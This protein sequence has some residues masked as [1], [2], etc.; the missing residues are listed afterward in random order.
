M[1]MKMKFSGENGNHRKAVF[2]L[3]KR[4]FLKMKKKGGNIR[5][6]LHNVKPFWGHSQAD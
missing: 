5:T 2:S 6:Y 4:H 1:S 3:G